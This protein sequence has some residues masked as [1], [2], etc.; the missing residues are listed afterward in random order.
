MSKN[1]KYIDLGERGKLSKNNKLNE[2]TG[3]E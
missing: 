3:K 2:L 1:D